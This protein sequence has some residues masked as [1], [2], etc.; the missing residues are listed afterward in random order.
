MSTSPVFFRKEISVLP[1]TLDANTIYAVRNGAGFDLYITDLTA[2]IAYSLNE[3]QTSGAVNVGVRNQSGSTIP[4][5]SV[6][7]INGVSNTGNRPL[8]ALA[9]ADAEA[10]STGTYGVTTGSISNNQNGQVRVIGIL[11]GL[12]TSGLTE[13]E[14]IWLSP[15]TAGGFTHTKPHAPNHAV[16]VG[17]VTKVDTTVGS[18]LVRIQNG[19]ELEE[20]HNVSINTPLSGQSIVYDEATGLWSN[21]DVTAFL[22]DVIT[23]DTPTYYYYGGTK[24]GKWYINRYSIPA[25]TKTTASII[26]NPANTTFSS[27]WADR[28]VLT[29]I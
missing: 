1:S 17:V 14:P 26:E 2:S 22:S 10:T 13:G 20:L 8:I 3:S 12:N 15:T 7:Y 29:Y 28:L 23:S 11:A 21:A 6:V 25:L 5:G 18:I 24:S 9:K 4:A 27:A 16:Y 19:Y